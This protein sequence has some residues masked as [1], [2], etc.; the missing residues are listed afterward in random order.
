MPITRLS[1]GAAVLALAA[2]APAA[3]ATASTQPPSTDPTATDDVDLSGVTLR[4]G[5]Q[6]TFTQTSLEASGQIDTPYTIE[7]ASFPAGPPLLEALAADAIDIGGVGD[8]PPIFAAAADAPIRVVLAT[9]TPQFT[10][11]I[12]V[13]DGSDIATVADLAGKTVA[14]T[15]GSSA[16]WLLLKALSD[17]GLTVD[18]V[19]ISYLL[20][21]DA[22][23]AFIGGDVDA[24][25]IWAPFT[26]VAQQDGASLLVNGDELGIP[27]YGFQVS[28]DAALSDPTKVA[29]RDFVSRLRVA[30]QW[31]RQHKDEWAA[32]Y[33]E[34]TGLDI[35]LATESLRF[36][37]QPVLLDEELIAIQQEEADGFYAAGLI[38]SEIDFAEFVDPQFN[39]VTDAILAETTESTTP[40]TT[41]AP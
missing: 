30:Q 9:A 12:L 36:D 4:V 27:G 8:A 26:I 31:Q 18:D 34:L 6:L 22:Q 11:G 15:K 21:T 23:Q 7:W 25:A 37:T 16:N 28:S 29:I 17:N 38:P 14:V 3:V 2:L 32:T 19:T 10:Q 1:V 39:D 20:P 24:W 40:A 41:E 33:S 13:P 5:D 35:D